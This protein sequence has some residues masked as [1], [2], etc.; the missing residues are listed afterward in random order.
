MAQSKG[1]SEYAKMMIG[2]IEKHPQL[3]AEEEAEMIA[4]YKDSDPDK[5]RELLVYHN[6]SYVMHTAT[7]YYDKSEEYDDFLSKGMQGIIEASQLYD[8]NSGNRF[9]TFAA[10]H[11][12]RR[13]AYMFNTDLADTQMRQATSLVYDSPL[14]DSED[15]GTMDG[16]NDT[17]Q[18]EGTMDSVR[19]H[20]EHADA[21]ADYEALV[22]A[23]CKILRDSTDDEKEKENIEL[24]IQNKFYKKS[25][26]QLGA[27]NGV[28]RYVIKARI[29]K[30][31]ANRGIAILAK[32][33]PELGQIISAHRRK[34]KD[35]QRLLE[36]MRN[37]RENAKA[38]DVAQFIKD[39][40]IEIQHKQIAEASKI[41]RME[42]FDSATEY[43]EERIKGHY[44]SVNFRLQRLIYERNVCDNENLKTVASDLKIPV[45]Y[46]EFLRSEAVER[47]RNYKEAIT[48]FNNMVNETPEI[49]A[50]EMGK[51][52]N[53]K[54]DD[55]DVRILVNG[56]PLNDVESVGEK[57]INKKKGGETNNKKKTANDAFDVYS[58]YGVSKASYMTGKIFRTGNGGYL[59]K[60]ENALYKM[61]GG[62][63]GIVWYE[64]RGSWYGY[65]DFKWYSKRFYGSIYSEWARKYRDGQ[66]RMTP[67]DLYWCVRLG[68]IPKDY[69]AL[70]KS[71]VDVEYTKDGRKSV[72]VFDADELNE[73]VKNVSPLNTYNIHDEGIMPTEIREETDEDIDLDEA[74]GL[75]DDGEM[76]IVQ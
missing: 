17:S 34:E 43:I 13:Q 64:R 40:D 37:K 12:K 23:Y 45:S 68:I 47:I 72:Q 28:S 19:A 22:R 50:T 44:G 30:V 67:R 7:K 33:D 54:S 69:Y 8:F 27:E 70:K 38:R 35:V 49:G 10:W 21:Q 15:S 14:G 62:T 71:S 20:K 26:D 42:M 32:A 29:D 56:K 16:I 2:L 1:Q 36:D 74:F 53:G 24:Y 76:E 25:L 55:S 61:S 66:V 73:V 31:E 3:S 60:K 18:V 11:I 65:T 46:A 75:N 6:L 9:L 63:E 52:G 5:L 4:K 51:I 57:V 48:K 41:T 39:N 58:L 59:H